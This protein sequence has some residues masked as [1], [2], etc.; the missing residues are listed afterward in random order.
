MARRPTH[1][2][3]VYVVRSDRSGLSKVGTTTDLDRRLGELS[4]HCKARVTLVAAAPGG[5]DVEE[6]LHARL[7]AH[8]CAG[9]WFAPC[10]EL[11]AVVA[12][13]RAVTAK[14]DAAR[15]SGGVAA[16]AL[17][18][19]SPQPTAATLRA[20]VLAALPPWLVVQER[21]GLPACPCTTRVV[22]TTYARAACPRCHGAGV[23]PLPEARP[24]AGPARAGS[25]P[26]PATTARSA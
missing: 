4:R 3:L 10:P 9:E 26:P 6:A 11:D 17:P 23:L 16:A 19:S 12:E 1:A 21:A 20:R 7:A 24:A 8:C 25:T 14:G 22:H 18:A 2:P 15:H 5:R 13:L